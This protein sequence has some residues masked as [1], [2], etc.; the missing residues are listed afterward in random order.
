MLSPSSENSLAG[1]TCLVTGGAGGLGKAIA[2][3]FLAAGANVVICDINEDRLQQTSAELGEIGRLKAIKTDI[4]SASA[5]QTL[6]DEIIADFGKLDI[7]VNNAGIMDRFDP[8]GDLDEALWDKV[9][10]VNL[11]APVLLSKLAVR[12][13]LA[14]PTPDG[15]IINIVSV[16]GKAGWAA[17][18]AYT[19][20]KHGLVGLTKN[21]AA[22]Y[23]NKGIRCNG[24]LLGGMNTN[25]TD[26]FQAGLNEE[27]KDK[28]V[29][30]GGAVKARLCEID[31][32]ADMCLFLACGKG[33]K[34]I[35]GALIPA[36]NGW[37]GVL[38]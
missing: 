3:T 38:G 24:L 29:E 34:L 32:V 5:V 30:I 19:A 28:A 17:G 4:T 26:A 20:S 14:Q 7:L 35:N 6:F 33:S 12:N 1:K 36:D 13:M 21:T 16:A 31:D 10:G 22:F 37:T 27:G 25:I 15:C 23:G 2:S 11:T 18:A 8:V 9:I